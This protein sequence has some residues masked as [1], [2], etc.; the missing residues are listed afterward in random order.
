MICIK[1]ST[2]LG[3]IE[4]HNPRPEVIAGHTALRAEYRRSGRE[5][6]D[7]H[8][9]RDAQSVEP[10]HALAPLALRRL[11]LLEQ[12]QMISLQASNN[13]RAPS[14]RS[15]RSVRR[16]SSQRLDPRGGARTTRVGQSE[17]GTKRLRLSSQDGGP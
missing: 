4:R 6:R 9:Q 11:Q 2:A 8:D 15:R 13:P 16:E 17:A 5:H 7:P 12:Q 3:T 1:R 14:C 10:N